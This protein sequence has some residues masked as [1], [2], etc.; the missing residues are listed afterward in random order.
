MATTDLAASWA[1]V[2]GAAARGGA[3]IARALHA[4]GLSVVVHHTPRSTPAAEEL[5]A[6]L[7]AQRAGSARAWCAEFSAPLAVPAWLVALGPAVLVCN[8]SVYRRSTLDD[9]ARAQADL[10]IH[11]HA[12]A[13]LL[14]ALL[15]GSADA[16]RAV[17]LRSVVAVTDVHVERPPRGYVWYAVAKAA[18]QALIVTLAV[19]WAPRVRFNAV[20]PGAMPFPPDWRDAER[21]A[22]I[23]ASIPL[24]RLGRFDDLARAVEWLALDADYVTG[25]VLAVDGGR[26]RH[27]D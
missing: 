26:S 10:A 14:A 1:L 13:A 22:R 25:Q 11:L 2:T 20:Q 15:P 19:E 17:A 7:C 12:H 4:R 18:L 16:D 9:A 21:T 8:A 5:V 24:Q 27:L 6:A 3:A 23:A